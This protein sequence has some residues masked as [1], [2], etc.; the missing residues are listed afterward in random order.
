MKRIEND[1][2]RITGIDGEVLLQFRNK[3]ATNVRIIGDNTEINVV[4]VVKHSDFCALR[5]RLAFIRVFLN[6]LGSP[7]RV[8]PHGFVQSAVDRDFVGNLDRAKPLFETCCFV[9]DVFSIGI[10]SKPQEAQRK[11]Q[12]TQRFH[13]GVQHY[14]RALGMR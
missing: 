4:T 8:G 7:R 2:E 9:I 14:M 11:T 3:D 6:K 5:H 10:G 13:I 12:K 1:L